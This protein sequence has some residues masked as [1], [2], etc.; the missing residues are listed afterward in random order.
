MDLL[1]ILKETYKKQKIFELSFDMLISSL[2]NENYESILNDPFTL[3]YIYENLE[4]LI[5]LEDIYKIKLLNNENFFKICKIKDI[6]K[7]INHLENDEDKIGILLNKKIYSKIF[8]NHFLAFDTL[9]LNFKSYDSYL[10]LLNKV[11][12]KGKII[13]L[14]GISDEDFVVNL[15]KQI[16]IE[17]EMDL[18]LILRRFTKDENKLLFLG[19][20]KNE[21]YIS[22][23]I[24]SLKDKNFI[25]EHFG[26]LT[27]NYKLTFLKTLTDEEKLPY[28]EKGYF[29]CELIASLENL[30]LLFKYFIGLKNYD[31]QKEVITNVK[32]ESLK[33]ELFKVMSISSDKYF[34]MIIYLLN[35]LNDK[36]IKL[37]LTSLLKNEGI[38]RAIKSNKEYVD[39]TN[40]TID[41][42]KNV[43]ENISIGIELECSHH[44]HKSYIALGSILGSWIIKEEGTVTNGV[45][46][47]S[48]ILHYNEKDLKSLKYICDFLKSNGF[49]VNPSC[50]G[51]IHLGFDYIKSVS[52]IQLIYY[53]YVHCEEIFAYMFNKE[54][55]TLREGAK[56]NAIFIKDNV[57]NNFG[58]YIETKANTLEYFVY[59]MGNVQKD[60]F[61]S[62][63]IKNAFSIN[64]NTLE[65]RIPNGT[66]DY[67]DVNLNII[68]FTRLLQ[69]SKYLSENISDKGVLKKLLILSED[70]P[71]EDKK[72][73]LLDIL[74]ADDYELKNIFYDRFET[75]YYLE[76]K[77]K[78]ERTKNTKT[79]KLL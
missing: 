64:K 75:N 39:L 30:D 9:K 69:E 52:H 54:G 77:M 14:K 15:L 22:E 71:I 58:K 67:E 62:L 21:Q 38:N 2:C 41:M 3:K 55:T 8:T 16:K 78:L 23:L 63:N 18:M 20:L 51:H 56:L 46:I 68:L 66:I 26:L 42:A 37:E 70:I 13:I 34:E 73:Y 76:T 33:Y 57:L 61:T 25:K 40:V 1:G 7:I 65:I 11:T 45:E 36:N 32:L 29:K 5:L 31:L 17:K 60:R 27:N 10:S 28:I 74:F 72:N 48:P 6:L 43:D 4:K 50:G 59:L 49:E 12:P 35:T 79:R 44:L 47:T 19:K 24:V 53:I